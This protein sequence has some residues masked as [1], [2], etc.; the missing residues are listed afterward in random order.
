VTRLGAPLAVAA[1]ALLVRAIAA[2]A[3]PFPIPEDSAY[4]IDAAR[5][6]A[7]GHGFVT[8]VVW[9][10]ATPPLIVPRPAFDLWQPLASFLAAPFMAVLGP[11][12]AATQVPSVVLGAA[13]APLAWLIARGAARE[14]GVPAGRADVIAFTSGLLVALT[15]LL[16]IQSAEPDSSAPYT[17]L[18]VAACALIPMSLRDEATARRARVLLGVALGLAYLAR[19]DAV[20]VAVAYVLV[21]RR[22]ERTVPSLA[23]AAIVAI[24]WLLRQATTWEASPLAQLIENAWSLRF[25]DIFAWSARPDLA[26]YLAAGPARLIGLR[27]DALI[28]DALVLLVAAFPAA[29]IGIV[30]IA[31]RPRLAVTPALRPLAIVALLTFAVDVLVFP[32]AGRAGL[33]AHG[34]GPAMVLLAIAGAMGLDRLLTAVG[35]IRS[36]Q[37]PSGP[38][39]RAGLIAPLAVAIVSAPLVAFVATLEHD[40]STATAAQYGAL[41]A[42]SA[43]WEVPPGRPIV[44]DHPMWL[45]EALGH[46]ALALPRESPASVI[47][48]MRHFRA[49][50][51]VIR[52]D[53]PQVAAI[54]LAIAAYRDPAGRTCFPELPTVAPFRAFGFGCATETAVTSP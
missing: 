11:S 45:A 30:A 31:A 51:V 33:W 13:M 35:T 8:D 32:V 29:P 19:S 4:Y 27:L 25:T 41:A 36:W 12:L 46:P 38:F 17:V 9:S 14:I 44:T 15:P 18:A 34:S 24:P 6:L 7:T 23:I 48:L 26:T 49:G 1:I 28:G 42:V 5:N 21:A 40:R 39:S 3:I 53:D 54:G 50:A 43:R 10:Y 22:L 37:V 47:D 20:Y 2:A 16:V 52:D